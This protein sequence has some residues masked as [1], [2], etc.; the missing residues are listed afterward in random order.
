MSEVTVNPVKL[1]DTIELQIDKVANGGFCIARYNG[2]AVFVR[3][4]LPGELVKAEVTEINKRYLRADAIEILKPSE[5]R[6]DSACIYSAVCGGCD[7][8]HTEISFQRELKSAVVIEQLAHL[9]NVTVV[10]G[11]DLSEFKVRALSANETGKHWRTRNRFANIAGYSIGMRMPRSHSVIEIED[12][13]IA[14]P[15]SVEIAKS[16]LHLGSTDIATAQSSTG[17]VV[18]VDQRGGPWLDEVVED[19]AWRIHAG[20]FWQVHKDAPEVF[21]TTVRQLAKLEKGDQLLD[22]YSG[23][24]LFAACLA[25][26]VGDAGFITA[27]ESSI[28]A[29]RDARRSCSDLAN[30]DLVTSDVAKWLTGNNDAFD[31]VVLDPPRTGAGATVIAQ[32]AKNTKRTI[33]YVACDPAALGRDTGYLAE[34]GWQMDRLVGYDAFPNTSHVECIASFTRK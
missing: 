15:E 16:A 1:G 29:V 3:H 12:C 28:D 31:V 5:H 23:A 2:Q 17:Q 21:V 34:H 26:D 10:N 14:T 13:L 25:K 11:E 7:W 6:I 18:L 24:G 20:S 9:G 19:R 4:S 33:V 22:L 27:V 32:I 30:I 8:Q